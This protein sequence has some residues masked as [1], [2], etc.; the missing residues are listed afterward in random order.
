MCTAATRLPILLTPI[1]CDGFF[2]QPQQDSLAENLRFKP[3]GGM[4]AGLAPTALSLHYAQAEM[5][6]APF[7]TLFGH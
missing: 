6:C 4:I 1:C 2:Y 5:M 7:D 3:H